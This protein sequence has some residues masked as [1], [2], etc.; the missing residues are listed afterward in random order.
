[1]CTMLGYTKRRILIQIV[2]ENLTYWDM[3]DQGKLFM[4]SAILCVFA[5]SNCQPLQGGLV[6]SSRC[7]HSRRIRSHSV[8]PSSTTPFV[9][10]THVFMLRTG[11]DELAA[12]IVDSWRRQKRAKKSL[13][14]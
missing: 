1:M 11:P 8:P 13:L 4:L 12:G 10:D 14:S 3:D 5:L 7:T 2:V 9:Y 6:P